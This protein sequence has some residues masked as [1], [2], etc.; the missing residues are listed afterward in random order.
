MK[1]IGPTRLILLNCGKF[2]YAE[3]NLDAPLHLVGPNN[4]GKTSL[5]AVLQYL[6]IDNQQKMKFS[7]DLITSR[8][9]YFPDVSSFALFESLGPEGFMLT[10]V[11][12]LGPIKQYE[13]ERYSYRGQFDRNDYLSPD[14]SILPWDQIKANLAHKN[15]SNLK[16]ADLRAALMGNDT[17]KKREENNIV[18]LSLVPLRR[19]D[20]YERFC[21]VFLNL[22]RLSHLR[23]DELK[24]LLL[25]LFD[26][27]FTKRRIDLQEQFAPQLNQ[28]RSQKADV[29][30]LKRNEPLIRRI[31]EG[32]AKR[33]RLRGLLKS[34]YSHIET[35]FYD[36][37]MEVNTQYQAIEAKSQEFQQV[38]EESEK[39]RHT[40][41]GQKE[42]KI[43][44]LGSLQ[45]KQEDLECLEKR[46]SQYN[47]NWANV[48]ISELEANLR[49]IESN[50]DM[51]Q[52]GSLEAIQRRLSQSELEL[53][54]LGTHL[55]DIDGS[56][57]SCLMKHLDE[58]QIDKLSRL[59]NDDILMLSAARN[60]ASVNITNRDLL[61]KYLKQVLDGFTEN[62]YAND[63]VV[64]DLYN[65]H[66]FDI[67]E[68]TDPERIR[69]KIGYT[70][71]EICKIKEAVHAATNQQELKQKKDT[72]KIQLC[73][74]QDECA[75][76]RNYITN[77]ESCSDLPQKLKI[78]ET[79]LLRLQEQLRSNQE[80][81]KQIVQ[82][83]VE[84]ENERHNLHS[85]YEQMSQKVSGLCR[86]SED[87]GV[88]EYEARNVGLADIL[89]IYYRSSNE[90]QH[91][92]DRIE[93]ELETI[94]SQTYD[95]YQAG[96]EKESLVTL[97][98]ELDTLDEKQKALEAGWSSFTVQLKKDFTEL[99]R[100]MEKL[101]AKVTKLNSDLSKVHISNLSNLKINVLIRT[102]L[103]RYFNQVEDSEQTPLFA[104]SSQ[105]DEVI[106]KISRI[107][108]EKPVI[109]LEDMFDM[110]FEITTPNGDIKK[111][112]HLDRIESNGTTIT[113]KVLINLIL[114]RGLLSNESVYV[115]FYLDECSSLDSENLRSIVEQA[116]EQGFTAILASPEAM[117]A[118]D[119]LYYLSE[120]KGRV[121]LNPK[122]SLVEIV[123]N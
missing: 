77:K 66:H 56:F 119:H 79:E 40:L 28:L 116:R 122:N 114:L 50:L 106:R 105:T 112:N 13:F 67:K 54:K 123:R 72:L 24:E 95:R 4:I 78:V 92:A 64:L 22:L 29:Y 16:P 7:R 63:A 49:S 46:F 26:G 93:G 70:E 5:I 89:E 113:I 117:D 82:K 30:D 75:Q 32:V 10:G 65:V 85:Q 31:L 62:I 34:L 42:Q 87:W 99:N 84:L 91:L 104:D 19:K 111:Y 103:K 14:N 53:D 102:E 58:Q 20:E 83:R 36:Y 1:R 80:E 48:K 6:Y 25:Q 98:N 118:A 90:H 57:I 101:L 45:Q 76:Y 2:D 61:N 3:I 69:E 120:N 68:Y 37:K 55:K 115:P 21:T 39:N 38:I 121:T 43:K 18:N 11:H 97:Q 44:E 107:L 74:L 108:Q 8:K 51:A 110:H 86:P 41:E 52:S 94:H 23:Q 60:K 81:H 15:Y 9:Y 96:T 88:I 17:R 47:L 100:D 71:K 109:S 59:F 35:S 12:G 33:D 27:E 73:T